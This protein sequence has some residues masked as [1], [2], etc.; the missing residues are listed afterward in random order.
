M[1]DADIK[2]QLEQYMQLMENDIV[3]KLSAGSD[4]VSKQMTELVE[5]IQSMSSKITVEHTK[6]ERTPSFSVNR[7]GEDTGI[8]FAGLPLGHEFT[9]LVLALLQVSGRAP[10]VDEKL[11]E[12]VK[13]LEGEYHF[14]TYVSLSCHNCP[15][16]VQALNVMA[17]LNPGVT[18]T[19]IEGNAYKDEVESKNILN[20]PTVFLNGEEWGG[21]RMELEEILNKLGSTADPSEFENKDPFDVLIVG[22]GPAGGSA[23]IYAARKGIRTGIVTDRFGGQILDT[24]TIE[25]FISVKE[26]QGDTLA[27]HIRDH[28]E[29]YNVDVM[30]AQ[31][32]KNIAKKDDYVEVELE[33]GAVLKSKTAIITTGARWR[34]IGVPGEQE[35]KTK[36]VAYCPHCDGP[37]FEGKDVAVIGGGNSGVE[38]AIDL[39]GIVNH[40]TVI[41]FADELKADAVLQ[42]NLYSLKNVTVIKNAAT[43]EIHGDGTK[44]TGLTYTDRAT[45]EDKY[46]DLDG[47]FVQIGLVPNTEWIDDSIEKTRMGEI[48]VDKK[49]A[50]NVPGIF[51]AGDCTDSAFKQIIISMG[52]GATAALGAFDYLMRNK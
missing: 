21:G 42:D 26:T 25:N 27:S 5:E 1:L 18:H 11:I 24:S 43:K 52:S 3:I 37:L 51:A 10:K 20:V 44:V 23:A 13:K 6:L 4:D 45:N 36:G 31:K 46:I 30:T 17:V 12:R 39:A 9:S 49:G 19:M 47:V 16:V 2:Q 15:V 14:E 22:G 33:N 38:A 40:V 50:T 28:V 48:I 32:A 8:V 35:Y 7:P 34:N 29:R 41:E